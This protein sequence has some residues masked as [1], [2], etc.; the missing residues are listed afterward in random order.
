MQLHGGGDHRDPA[1]ELLLGDIHRGKGTFEILFAQLVVR[2]QPVEF[3]YA[4]FDLFEDLLSLYLFRCF[5]DHIGVDLFLCTLYDLLYSMSAFAAYPSGIA[6]RFEFREIPN[7][8]LYDQVYEILMVEMLTA[9]DQSAFFIGEPVFVEA[10]EIDLFVLFHDLFY[11]AY[12]H[13]RVQADEAKQSVLL[14]VILVYAFVFL[15]VY[16]DLFKLFS[17]T[18]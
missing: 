17:E 14:Q 5:S 10:F 15:G 8:V 11:V 16:E 4:F 2:M 12:I 13:I 1:V 9:A 6:E 18:G 3:L 7:T